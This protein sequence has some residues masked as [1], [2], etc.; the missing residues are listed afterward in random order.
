MRQGYLLWLLLV[1]PAL[2][3]CVERTLTINTQPQGATVLLNDEEIG[4]SP[5]TV[6][7]NW[8]G[9][10]RVQCIKPGYEILETHRLLEAPPHDTFPFDFF[11]GVLWPGQIIDEYEWTFALS[12]YQPPDRNT[13]IDQAQQMKGKALRDLKAPLPADNASR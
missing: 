4:T 5:I 11:Y 8:Y 3:G 9:D 7:F 6:S 12:A 1:L 13:L 2:S 10:Y